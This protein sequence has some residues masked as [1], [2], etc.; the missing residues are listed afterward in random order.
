MMGQEYQNSILGIG[1]EIVSNIV[2]EELL[3][4]SQWVDLI[5]KKMLCVL[6]I[7]LIFNRCPAAMGFAH[8]RIC[9]S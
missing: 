4:S 1:A 5:D 9:L 6:A 7:P 3:I 8:K 2:L